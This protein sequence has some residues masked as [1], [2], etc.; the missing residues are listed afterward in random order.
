MAAFGLLGYELD[1]TQVSKAEKEVIAAQVQFYKEHRKLF[2]Y[3]R[4][5]RLKSPFVTSEDCA[6]MVVSEDKKEALVME[7]IGRLSPNS[8]TLPLR[9]QGLEPDIEY[10]VTVRRQMI[11]IRAFGSLI[12]QVLPVKVDSD[13]LLVHIAAGYYMLPCEEESYRHVVIC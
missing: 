9:M 5:F 1:L 4:F 12:N 3:G 2:Q 10:E 11:D 7:A 8:E 6:W 13:G